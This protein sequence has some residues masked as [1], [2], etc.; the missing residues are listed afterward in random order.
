MV[1]QRFCKP[2]VVGSNP[3]AG[4]PHQWV[5]CLGVAVIVTHT[6]LTHATALGT[7]PETNPTQVT[8]AAVT[9]AQEFKKEFPNC[10]KSLRLPNPDLPPFLALIKAAQEAQNQHQKNPEVFEFRPIQ[11]TGGDYLKENLEAEIHWLGSPESWNT[12]QKK[13]FHSLIDT[14]NTLASDRD[15]LAFVGRYN[16]EPEVNSYFYCEIDKETNTLFFETLERCD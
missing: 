10:G 11:Y 16:F 6:P 14:L 8:A 3:T 9:A 1:E 13:T 5:L 15:S 4:S 2:S 7:T 12:Q